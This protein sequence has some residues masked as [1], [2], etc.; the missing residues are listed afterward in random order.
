MA[1][2]HMERFSLLLI[3]RE[4]QIKITRYYFTSVRTATIKKSTND[5]IWR[6]R[7]EKGTLLLCW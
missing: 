5:K 7:G 6:G 2:R 3:I 1:D 4:M